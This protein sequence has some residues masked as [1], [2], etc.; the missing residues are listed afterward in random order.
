MT[1]ISAK[2]LWSWPFPVFLE[3]LCQEI[4]LLVKLHNVWAMFCGGVVAY[5]NQLGW[6]G[7]QGEMRFL[8]NSWYWCHKSLMS[9]LLFLTTF[10][11]SYWH[12]SRPR[13]RESVTLVIP[14]PSICAKE[15]LSGHERLNIAGSNALSVC[16]W[17]RKDST[18]GRANEGFTS[19]LLALKVRKVT[20]RLTSF[21]QVVSVI[22][23]ERLLRLNSLV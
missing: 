11:L 15:I 22:L 5:L 23:P 21:S 12:L 17:L 3:V 7:L 10:A 4:K 6:D 20:R 1:A 8:T 2:Q 19:N 9:S 16:K 18:S 14:T 13:P